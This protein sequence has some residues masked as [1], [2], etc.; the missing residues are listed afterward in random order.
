MDRLTPVLSQ[1]LMATMHAGEAV[2]QIVEQRI[3]RQD[4]AIKLFLTQGSFEQEKSLYV[5]P[6]MPLGKFLPKLRMIV[7]SPEGGFVDALG[8][9]MPPCIVMEK[10]EALDTWVRRSESGIDMVTGV[11]VWDL[12]HQCA[13]F[14]PCF[15]LQTLLLLFRSHATFLLTGVGLEYAGANTH[16]RAAEGPACCGLRAPRPQAGQHH[17]A[18]AAKPLDTHRLWLR[19]AHRRTCAVGLHCRLRCAR[20]HSGV[21]GRR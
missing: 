11:Q 3:T 8:D 20:S 6:S 18:A 9:P 21:P 14:T 1:Q 10:G 4:F 19:F 12:E 5:D 13:R 15:V 7:D 17:V 16:R 2:V